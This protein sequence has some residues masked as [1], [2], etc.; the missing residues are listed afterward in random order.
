MVNTESVFSSVKMKGISHAIKEVAPGETGVVT[1]LFTHTYTLKGECRMTTLIIAADT[2]GLSGLAAWFKRLN[3]KIEYRNNIRK[4]INELSKL[5]DAE[6]RDIG[7]GRGEIY[8]IAHSSFKDDY[9]RINSN[10]KGWV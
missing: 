4:T 6:L 3:A 10:L 1:T 5:S 9:A 2:I 8:E 7:I